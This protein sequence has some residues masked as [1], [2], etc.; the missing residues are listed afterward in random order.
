[1]TVCASPPYGCGRD[2]QVGRMTPVGWVCGSCD[3][4]GSVAQ[5]VS[6]GNGRGGR[7]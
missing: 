5:H 2:K 6:R 3:Q 7:R 4:T 1:M